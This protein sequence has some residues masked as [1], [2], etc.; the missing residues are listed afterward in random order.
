VTNIPRQTEYWVKSAEEDFEVGRHLIEVD[1][2]RHGLFFIHLALEK[3]LKA[4]FCK[5]QNKTPPKIHNLLSLADTAGIKLDDQQ[6][7]VLTEI[8]EFNLEGR[9]PLD[10]IKPLDKSGAIKYMKKAQEAFECF[11]GML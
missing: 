2:T 5:N 1:K 6:K 9:Y 4:C 7:D 11:R 3:M 8:N 10:F